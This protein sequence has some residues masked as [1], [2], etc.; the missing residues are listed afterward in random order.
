VIKD[1][2]DNVVSK[3]YLFVSIIILILVITYLFNK[4]KKL[5][6]MRRE[7][8]I[9]QG[10]ISSQR[11]KKEKGSSRF[12]PKRFADMSNE[13]LSDYRKQILKNMKEDKKEEENSGYQYKPPKEGKGLFS[14]FD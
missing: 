7:K 12:T 11:I 2:G 10:Y 3:P 9:Q 14:M 1:T 4:N 8:E 5:Q 13:E 6:R